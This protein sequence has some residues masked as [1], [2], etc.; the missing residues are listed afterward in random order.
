MTKHLLNDFYTEL[1]ST[2]SKENE[3]GFKSLIRLNPLHE[4]YKGHFPQVPVAPG[5]VLV[6]IIKESQED[7]RDIQSK[8]RDLLDNTKDTDLLINIIA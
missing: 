8:L 3:T 7:S 1:S 6:Q 2:F 5:V 4:V